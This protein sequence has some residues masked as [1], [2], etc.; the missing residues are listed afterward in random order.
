L[1]AVPGRF[2]Q[3]VIGVSMVASAVLSFATAVILPPNRGDIAAQVATVAGAPGRFIAANLV[4]LASLILL[5]PAVV[6]LIY[7]LRERRRRLAIA[8]GGLALAGV[9]PVAVQVALGFVEWKMVSPGADRREMVALL[10]RIEFSA[11]FVPILL[12]AALPAI[13]LSMLAWGLWLSRTLPGWTA[14]FI[15][16]GAVGLDVG[17]EIPSLAVRIAAAA[18]TLAAFAWLGRAVVSTTAQEWIRGSLAVSIGH[19]SSDEPSRPD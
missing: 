12:A 18:L 4:A 14:T 6:G 19:D 13:G 11:G 8:A 15:A 9:M 17:F 7:L 10:D 16:L 1:S 5:V 2:R 3:H